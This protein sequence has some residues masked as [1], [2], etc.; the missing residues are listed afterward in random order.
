MQSTLSPADSAGLPRQLETIAHQRP[1][2][3]ESDLPRNESWSSRAG[4]LWPNGQSQL[5]SA[6]GRSSGRRSAR[7]LAIPHPAEDRR[8]DLHVGQRAPERLLGSDRS[9][10]A[11]KIAEST[12]RSPRDWRNG[13]LSAEPRSL[14]R[15]AA[16]ASGSRP[17]SASTAVRIAGVGASR[18]TQ[19]LSLERVSA[20][21]VSR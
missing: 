12:R 17:S 21:T 8:W 15:A 10:S 14:S 19:K 9:S 5:V 16:R 4:D 18:P 20:R 13:P 2:D 3:L 7:S 11:G 1:S 6:A